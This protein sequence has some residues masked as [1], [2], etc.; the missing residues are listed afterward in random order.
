MGAV[1][2]ALSIDALT[3][4]LHRGAVPRL[5]WDRRRA[6]A[7]H[8]VCRFE[9]LL[10]GTAA[11]NQDRERLRATL[12]RLSTEVDYRL[13]AVLLRAVHEGDM[14]LQETMHGLTP[15]VDGWLV[16]QLLLHR[17]PCT[18]SGR[19]LRLVSAPAALASAGDGTFAWAAAPVHAEALRLMDRLVPGHVGCLADGGLDVPGPNARVRGRSVTRWWLPDGTQVCTKRGIGSRRQR[20]LDEQAIR[21]QVRDRLR[22]AAGGAM[23]GAWTI[24]VVEDVA[25]LVEGETTYGLTRWVDGPTMEALLL[26]PELTEGHRRELLAAFHRLL[27]LLFDLGVL[28]GDMCPR[29]IL[30]P[31]G[32]T[33]HRLVL[34]DFEKTTLLASPVGP[35]GRRDWCR[36]QVAIEELAVLVSAAELRG[37]LR[38][39]FDPDSWDATRSG[40]PAWPLRPDLR[41]LLS[42]R[43]IQDPDAGTCNRLDREVLQVRLPY[44]DRDGGWVRPGQLGFCVQ[45]YMSVAGWDSGEEHERVTTEVLLAGQRHGYFEEVV[46]LLRAVLDDVEC[47][48]LRDEF[49]Q[50]AGH[51]RAPGERCL[52][53]ELERLCSALHRLQAAADDGSVALRRAV[54][55][56]VTAR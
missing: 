30:V 1:A 34:L 17:H 32:V 14:A 43:R 56:L 13:A 45:H 10:A 23:P 28:W 12:V 29:N 26:D 2:S 31:A 3:H 22:D 33:G 15:P 24:D 16:S 53:A 55:G 41:N 19:E 7:R 9:E 39:W 37:C 35:A 44:R 18:G 38:E 48:A 20:V 6:V 54:A 21:A 51:D 52:Q 8:L 47:A 5:D 36:G 46:Q 11:P 4:E 27:G 40:R 25:L 50:L 49:D 42:G